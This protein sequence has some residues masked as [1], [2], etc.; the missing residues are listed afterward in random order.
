MRWST[1]ATRLLGIDVPIVLA[2]LGGG[3]GTVALA[4]AVCEAGGLG[5]LAGG[6]LDPGRLRDDIRAARA[7]TD[8]PFAV[9]VFAAERPAPDPATVEAAVA[10]VAPLRRELGLPERPDRLPPAPD[11]DGQLEVVV[12]ER[13]AVVSFAFGLLPPAAVAALHEAGCVLVG[14]A[15]TVAEA[16]ALVDAGADAVCAQG[17]EAGG[18][19]GSFLPGPG[20]GL[21]GTFALVPQVCDAVDVPVLAAG[22][23]MDGRGVAA[24]LAL[25]AGAAQMGTAFLRCPE[26]G[27][28]PAHRAALAAA[29][30]TST[31]VSRHVTGRPVRGIANRLMRELDGLDVPAYPVM[32]AVTAELRRTAAERGDPGLMSLWAG[33]GVALGGDRPAADVVADAVAGAAAVLDSLA[34]AAGR[35]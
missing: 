25:G 33:Q 32:H 4:V 8:R 15:T 12:A 5:S 22:G 16:V 3:P 1:P 31:A 17:V 35:R 7:A 9:N 27:T 14:T 30:D 2:P 11:L 21:V 28:P 20:A 13:P 10:A 23:I 24:A 19:R 29:D 6:Y 34:A 18:H 26:A